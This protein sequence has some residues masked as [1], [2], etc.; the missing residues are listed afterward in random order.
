MTPEQEAWW[1]ENRHQPCFPSLPPCPLSGKAETP[2]PGIQQEMAA[3]P[4]QL[5]GA[6]QL[7][8]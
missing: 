8:G 7:Q 4:L 1:A 3:K 6:E 2:G 5:L